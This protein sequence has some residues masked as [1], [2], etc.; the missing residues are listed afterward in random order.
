MRNIMKIRNILCQKDAE[1]LAHASVT[2]RLEFLNSLSS[3]CTS[4]SVKSLQLVQ[5]SAAR[6]LTGT[7]GRDHIAPVLASFAQHLFF[8]SDDTKYL[9]EHVYRD[10]SLPIDVLK[11]AAIHPQ[12]SREVLLNELVVNRAKWLQ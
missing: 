6:V 4:K 7:R 10:C 11:L 12:V 8:G 5:N 2:S 1:K 9:S 3:G